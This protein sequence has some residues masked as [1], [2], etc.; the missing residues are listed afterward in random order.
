LTHPLAAKLEGLEKALTAMAKEVEAVK[1][2]ELEKP[3]AAAVDV[4]EPVDPLRTSSGLGPGRIDTPSIRQ[5]TALEERGS[6]V[7]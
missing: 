1:N 4:M 2:F 6:R 3:L 5:Q 7:G